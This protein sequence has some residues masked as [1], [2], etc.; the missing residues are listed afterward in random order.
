LERSGFK[1]DFRGKYKQRL[2]FLDER[3]EKCI[4]KKDWFEE[5]KQTNGL[6]AMKFN[7]SQKNIRILFTFIKYKEIR[8][9]LLLNAFEEKD[10]KNMSQ[11]SHGKHIPLAQKRLKEVINND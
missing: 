4:L 9:V 3:Q 6:Y 11:N 2:K 7:K 8:Y 1:D 5:L 10:H